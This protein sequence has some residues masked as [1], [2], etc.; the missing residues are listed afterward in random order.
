MTD[1]LLRRFYIFTHDKRNLHLSP[2]VLH[3]FN[4][5]KSSLP[6]LAAAVRTLITIRRSGDRTKRKGKSEAVARNDNSDE[7]EPEYE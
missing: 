7:D 1:F 3:I 5:F 4:T 6:S 2:E